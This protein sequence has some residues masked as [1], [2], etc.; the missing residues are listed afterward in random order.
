MSTRAKLISDIQLRIYQGKPSDDIELDEPQIAH[1]IDIVRDE[2]LTK[3]LNKDLSNGL[4]VNGFYVFKEECLELTK[5]SIECLEVCS[6]PRFFVTLSFDAIPL[7]KDGG[8]IRV[9]DNYGR[10]LTGTN[11]LFSESLANIPY[12]RTSTNRQVFYKENKNIYI[13][14]N[15]SQSAEI[16][17]YTVFYVKQ[18]SDS[19]V[20]NQDDYPLEDSM[21]PELMDRVEEIA[22]REMSL[23]VS[24][25]ENDGTDPYNN[26]N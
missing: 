20:S 13:S 5:E 8:I 16:Y 19:D 17:K 26:K 6:D 12:R 9:V 22:R 18:M 15:T 11:Q 10:S 7:Y 23:G 2:I 1:W 3:K 25:Q 24:D 21:I 4:T 14:D